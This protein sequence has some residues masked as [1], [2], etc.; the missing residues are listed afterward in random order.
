MEYEEEIEKYL[1]ENKKLKSMLKEET[2]KG[3]KLCEKLRARV[4]QVEQ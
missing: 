2:E 1:E 3:E 4:K